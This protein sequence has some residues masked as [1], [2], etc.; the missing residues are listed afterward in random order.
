MKIKKFLLAFLIVLVITLGL[1]SCKKN[2]TIKVATNAQFAPFEYYDGDEIKGFDIDLIREYGKYANVD[3]EIINMDFDAALISVST[4]KAD[5]AIAGITS[6]ETRKKILSF[7]NPYYS[8]DQV[9]IVRSNSKY[10]S[11]TNE[12]DLLEALSH[13]SA[14]I[15]CQR[16]TTGQY[17]IEGDTEWGFAGIKNATC[18]MYDDGPLAVKALSDA[19][20]DAVI[21]D[22]AP[23]KL[24]AKSIGGVTIV[25][26]V[27]LTSEEYAVAINLE[28]TEL[29][30]S[31]NEFIDSFKNGDSYNKLMLTYFGN[32]DI[33]KN[34]KV[35]SDENIKSIFKGLGNTFLIT[36]VAFIIGILVGTLVSLANGIQS[37]RWYA[38]LAKGVAKTY[39]ALFRGTPIMVQLLIIYYVIFRFFEGN[40]IWIA[41]LAFGLN[42]GA[43]V[44]EIIRGGINS[45]GTGQMEAARSLGLPYH[46]V[47]RR[48]ILPQGIKNCLPSLG[49]EFISL[50][51]ET[52]VVGFI[53][54][55]DLTLAFRKI[56]NATFD[57]TTAY[58]VMGLV[59]FVIVFLI[60]ICLNYL[61][62][63]LQH[64][65]TK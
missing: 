39:V 40:A 49:N 41:M 9:V 13:D 62:R 30:N 56:A 44:S 3:V 22:S 19:K 61:E 17:Y 65:R 24:Y 5:L 25:D 38:Y 21:I 52:S 64:D 20:I 47:M 16:G 51:K 63:R 58:L 55:F 50:I 14:K 10:S 37:N 42:S 35:F 8:A 33:L 15:G 36:F 54:A 48:V 45:V 27:V 12:E 46:T 23:A 31:I 60:T 29:L 43:Y 26:N 11:L 57:Y 32:E 59:Y 34:N 18:K 7:S 6:N 2:K 1:S 4:K 53:G 28:D